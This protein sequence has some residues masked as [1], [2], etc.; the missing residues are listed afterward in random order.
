[1]D[2]SVDGSSVVSSVDD[3]VVCSV[4]EGS[5]VDGSGVD[6]VMVSGS[7]NV[8]GL[9]VVELNGDVVA[10]EVSVVDAFVEGPNVVAV[11]ALVVSVVSS[12]V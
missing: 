3:S 5:D 9:T 6:G 4:V 11:F 2:D 7:D 1:M 8:V 12:V 10:V